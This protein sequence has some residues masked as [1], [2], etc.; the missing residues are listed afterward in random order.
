LMSSQV[1]WMVSTAP[2][3]FHLL[4]SKDRVLQLAKGRNAKIC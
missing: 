3:I 4:A 1:P 2:Y